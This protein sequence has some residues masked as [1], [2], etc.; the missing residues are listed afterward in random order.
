M[1]ATA[2]TDLCSN[3]LWEEVI[4]LQ[5]Q[6]DTAANR[7]QLRAYWKELQTREQRRQ[8]LEDNF[9]WG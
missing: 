2:F 4:W 7:R 9:A 1:I 5:D 3:E 8:Y 6:P